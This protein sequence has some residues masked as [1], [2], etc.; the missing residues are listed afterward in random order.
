MKRVKSARIKQ[1]QKRNMIILS[2]IIICLIAIFIFNRWTRSEILKTTSVK[3]VENGIGT[4]VIS[5]LDVHIEEGGEENRYYVILPDKVNGYIVNKLFVNEDAE[6]QGEETDQEN[7]VSDN[8]IADDTNTI[9]EDS[10]TVSNVV[11]KDTNTLSDNI[12][13]TVNDNSANSNT[14]NENTNTIVE[15]DNT[16]AQ[17]IDSQDDSLFDKAINQSSENDDETVDEN[18]NT[19]TTTENTIVENSNTVV[20]NKDE[21]VINTN[22]TVNNDYTNTAS[23]TAIVNKVVENTV[24]NTIKNTLV[25]STNTI[26]DST[27]TI[28]D[29]TIEES[30]ELKEVFPGNIVYL[31]EDE[32][33]ADELTYIVEFNTKEINGVRLYEQ[34]LVAETAESNI[35]VKGFVPKDYLLNVV[36][37]DP[38][39]IQ[40]L[41]EDMEEFKNTTVLAAYDITIMKEELEY[42][43]VEFNQF[44]NVAITSKEKLE[45]NEII[46]K[47]IE[48]I[49]INETEEEIIFERLMVSNKTTDTVECDTNE[50]SRYAVVE[51]NLF[52]ADKITI[53]NFDNDY[54]YY[55]GL[56]YTEN[57]VG[58]E[59][60]VK[61]SKDNLAKVTVNYYGYKKDESAGAIQTN[62]FEWGWIDNTTQN[63]RRIIRPN[64]IVTFDDNQYVDFS[65]P[66]KLAFM[67]PYGYES[68]FNLEATQQH[69]ANANYRVSRDGN[70]IVIEADNWNSWIALSFTRYYLNFAMVFNQT[71]DVTVNNTRNT[72]SSL[73]MYVNGTAAIPRGYI[74]TAADERQSLMTY[75]HAAPINSDGSVSIEL[76][77]NPFVDRP[78]GR[79]FDGWRA[80]NTTDNTITMNGTNCIQTLTTRQSLTANANGVKE[81]TVDLYAN[82]ATANVIIYDQ[83]TDGD[84]GTFESPVNTWAEINSR[85]TGNRKYATAA[86]SRELNIIVIT[87]GTLYDIN[88]RNAVPYT[89]TSIYGG[90]DYRNEG[91]FRITVNSTSLNKDVQLAF[92]SI[93]GSSNYRNGGTGGTG[94]INRRIIGNTYNLRLGRGMMPTD[95]SNDAATWAQIQGG[96]TARNTYKLV[97]ESGKY[98]NLQVGRRDDIKHNVNAIFVAGNDID[99]AKGTTSERNTFHVYGKIASHSGGNKYNA[100]DKSKPLFDMRIK[101]GTIGVDGYNALAG[102]SNDAAYCGIYLGGHG[103]AQN[104]KDTRVL[105]IEGGRIANVIG[106][107]GTPSNN[108]P[109]T[110]IYVKGGTMMNIVGGA[111][112]SETYGDRCIQVTD[113]NVEYSINGGSNGVYSGTNEGILSGSSLLYV[114]GNAIIGSAVPDDGNPDNYELYGSKAGCVMG[115]GNGNGSQ[116]QAGRVN[117]SRII[118]DGNALIKNSV[119]GGGNYGPIYGRMPSYMQGTTVNNTGL[120]PNK[121][122]MIGSG[123]ESGTYFNRNGNNLS[124]A[125]FTNSAFPNNSQIWVFEDAG[126]GSFYIKNTL[127]NRYLSATYQTSTQSV[128]L[129]GESRWNNYTVVTAFN[130][131]NISLAGEANKT[132]FLITG[133]LTSGYTIKPAETYTI[134]SYLR[135][136]WYGNV[137]GNPV[138]KSPDYYLSTTSTTQMVASSTTLFIRIDE[139]IVE[140][141]ET[142][143]DPLDGIIAPIMIDILGGTINRN[144]YGGPNQKYANGNVK[145]TMDAGT[146]YGAIYG[147]SNQSGAISGN[148]DIRVRGGTLGTLDTVDSDRIFG[149]GKGRSTS[150][151]GNAS[152]YINDRKN[153]L[154]IYGNTFG[155]SEA[156]GVAGD[157]IVTM[158]DRYVSANSITYSG[159]I[160]GGGKGVGATATNGANSTVIVD[161]GTYQGL[162]IFG[163]CDISGTIEGNILVKVGE[164]NT[165]KVGSVYGAGRNSRVTNVTE[166]VYVH[167]YNNAMV[168]ENVFNGGMN[169]GIDGTNPRAVYINGATVLQNVYGGS[170]SSG[171]LQFT[172]VYCFNGA[173]VS[174]SVFG[175]GVGTGANVT[176]NTN[177]QI[178]SNK[179]FDNSGDEANS[180]TKIY[181][182]VYGGGENAAV[183][184]NTV[185]NVTNA[186]I[187]NNVFGGG[188]KANVT[189]DTDVDIISSQIN[190]KVFG[191]GD[192]AAVSGETTVDI[193]GSNVLE[194]VYGGGNQGALGA[195]VTDKYTATIKVSNSSDIATVYGGGAAAALNGQIMID[196]DNSTID[197][198]YGAGEGQ[199]SNV[200]QT[201]DV[202]VSDS[203][204]NKIYGGGFAG[205]IAGDIMIGV[206][207]CTITD[208]VYGAGQGEQAVSS[209]DTEVSIVDSI[210]ATN[211]FGGGDAG[212]LGG[213][214]NV[215]VTNTKVG[216]NAYGGGNKADV[217]ESTSI[218]FYEESTAKVV[219]GGGNNGNVG[220]TTSVEVLERSKIADTVY[221]GGNNGTVGGFT[222]VRVDDSDVENV[223]FGGGKGATAT[224]QGTSIAF[225][226][227]STTE[228]I[229]GGGDQGRVEGSTA[230]QTTVIVDASTVGKNV[231]AGG[232]G[233]SDSTTKG[234]VTGNTNLIIRNNATIGDGNQALENGEA[235]FDIYGD[236][237]YNGNAFG[238]GR[239][240]TA[241]VTGDTNVILN[242]S[243]VKYNIYGGGDN[244]DIVGNTTVRLTNGT[245]E[246]SAFAAGNGIPDEVHTN[247]IARVHENSHIILEG[248]TTVG[249]HVFGSGNAAKTGQES[250]TTSKAIVDI[251]GG[252]IGKS[253]YGG[254]NSSL[255]NGDTVTNIGVKAIDRY[256]GTAQGYQQDD[257][258]ING[259][260]FGGGE[261]MKVG[262]EGFDFFS[263]SVTGTTY[264]NVDGDTYNTATGP[265]LDFKSSIF[266]SGNASSANKSGTITIR[267]YGTLNDPKSAISLQRAGNV[268]IDK[269]ALWLSGTTDS[270]SKYADTYF[271]LNIIDKFMIKNNSTLYLRNGANKVSEFWSMTGEDGSETKAVV[272]IPTIITGVDGET[273]NAV[274]TKAKKGSTDYLVLD[275]V[276]YNKNADGT[277]GEKV[278]DVDLVETD[279][280]NI[281]YNVDNRIYMYS[282]INLDIAY[283]EGPSDSDYGPVYGMTFFGMYKNA[284]GTEL[285]KGMYDEDYSQNSRV[286]W[287][288]RDYNRCYVQGQHKANHVIE[289][290]G[291]YTSFEQLQVELDAGESLSQ[292]KY[293]DTTNG[294]QRSI[295]Y[296]NY[297]D[298]TPEESAYYMWYCGPDSE[299]FYYTFNLVASKFSTLGTK[300][301]TLD[302]IS[303]PNATIKLTTVES[304]LIDTANLVDKNTIPNINP[305]PDAANNVLGL[306]MKTGNSGWAMNGETNYYSENSVASRDGDSVYIIEN[307]GKSPALDFYLYHSNNITVTQELGYY[308]VNAEMSW[309]K[310][311]TRGTARII[312]D[313]ALSTAVYEGNYYN[314]AITPGRQFE[315][316]TTTP[317]DITTDSSFSAFFELS[318]YEFYEIEEVQKMYNEDAYRVLQTDYQLPVN[319]TITM[320]DRHD[321]ANPTY[322]YYT[323]TQEDVTDQKMEYLLSDF[324]EMGNTTKKYDEIGMMDKYYDENTKYQY[325]CFIFTVD[326][327][328]AE[329]ADKT[330]F[331]IAKDQLFTMA[332]RGYEYDDNGNKMG[333]KPIFAVMDEQL[334]N[335]NYGLYNTE[336]V[337]KITDADL[338]KDTIYPGSNTTLE[339]EID[340]NDSDDD[341]AETTI[342][343]HDTRFFDKKMGV[344]ISLT[345]LN[346][347]TGVYEVVPGSSLMGTYFTIT[348]KDTNGDE[349]KYN[350]YPR[351]DGT[352]RIKLAEKVS[353]L[354]SEIDINTEN[355]TLN[356]DFKI[357][358]E[359]FGSADGI[360]FGVEAS[361]SREVD[362]KVVD[363]IYG[364]NTTIPPEQ[365][366]IDK[367]TGHT[368]EPDTGYIS[369][370]ENAVDVTLEYQSGLNRPYIT[371]KLLRRNYQTVNSTMYEIVDLQDYVNETLTPVN[372]ENEYKALDTS[373]IN[374]AV[375]NPLN[376]EEFIFNYTT[377]EDLVSGTYKLL[378]TLY[379]L[380]DV[381]IEDKDDNGNVTGTHDETL[382]QYI[383]DTHSYLVIK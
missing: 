19:N 190:K 307:S 151:N 366:I 79:G 254:A 323:V 147:G 312:I 272:T 356:G 331:E 148:V 288:D 281:S 192:E 257:I 73:G 160:F 252:I 183:G 116:Q 128:K 358:I 62:R 58:R 133:S 46:K 194:A 132:K 103:S 351:A 121:K 23:N 187:G 96:G 233:A 213:T 330:T 230:S 234:S 354:F 93:S 15:K 197:T 282:G 260:I 299:V 35:V 177:V 327:E 48:M 285:Y 350:Y 40:K 11:T 301:L 55:M 266:A 83:D 60:D 63:Q 196:V 271:T 208:A 325:E 200:T 84:A 153:N 275:G 189:G 357:V 129:D 105:T 54:N 131:V 304:S 113:G 135:N 382:Y 61:Y 174:G 222:S 294:D 102:N 277:A 138:T 43:P 164:E 231:F 374:A 184:G 37:E 89:I 214:A 367:T 383:G 17:D 203:T 38:T 353:N 283:E 349:H 223:V 290:D 369:E 360:Y 136:E 347:D 107:L 126:D 176:G 209:G 202:D 220:T 6:V 1:K 224:V 169:A 88:T 280:N 26:N 146:V 371:V 87:D 152:I 210:V 13:T 34:E 377:K 168:Y 247:H 85:L 218:I 123:Q 31:T 375:E 319:T 361:D 317:T 110:F 274:G 205:D 333:Y 379:D 219:Y 10:N 261:S 65:K 101:S 78:R 244:G 236:P 81:V 368:L 305:D 297:I 245:V 273:Y 339:L 67:I 256:Y 355:S 229:Y 141:P 114:G 198:I 140:Q 264:I 346:N 77:D 313:I 125:T 112:R 296:L 364:L 258:L 278:T 124:T 95:T 263:I 310:N 248:T 28:E 300:S 16:D 380:E 363:N 279:V 262:V 30:I 80:I 97:I 170:D 109:F 155:G 293:E 108:P 2:T 359:S 306:A 75:T 241:T 295:S 4:E 91:S 302:G 66:F 243:T 130:G 106:G 99:R 158:E 226:N 286:N 165:T 181:T 292:T 180:T 52:T 314:A 199:A 29:T 253:V 246:S 195:N 154:T 179:I 204:V 186:Q 53:N 322:Y 104:D 3:F 69:A 76:I 232:N 267:N 12:N 344:R 268:I 191:G 341:S 284:E 50:F 316:F 32:V 118:I 376:I 175:A 92:L 71:A 178:H 166:S 145:I 182:N 127:N 225:Q 328:S 167:C 56:N 238:G 211:V 9:I 352:T 41:M 207:R 193:N 98:C 335:M 311:L 157:S 215:F 320:I 163:G 161:G 111:G 342:A 228:Y 242:S 326:F 47:D 216:E 318:E 372:G 8:T 143:G 36:N 378:Y 217:D 221:G 57:M 144:V 370:T 115:A 329:F 239:G 72:P 250:S 22:T 332:L 362:L 276:I 59:D 14:V 345:Q 188:Q 336:S 20:D 94:N 122:Y 149:G 315:L 212:E 70:A 25:Q 287:V 249:K 334:K 237:I 27:N 82:W 44:V 324:L 51:N 172:N 291:F 340:Y 119:Y 240:L 185:V 289:E 308:R 303:Y 39:E 5:E 255:V 321:N 64:A 171:A 373:E 270:T 259:T 21:N 137:Y 162:T 33:I 365:T 201:T 206:K 68:R 381:E 120:D 117:S 251:A 7:T 49:H 159:I 150:I 227:G 24:V 269:S 139:P 74:S 309:K 134:Y 235:A 265:T 45:S 142:D 343:V 156:G 338:T 90:V 100:A 337:I 18:T 86:S 173:S 42:Q 298:P 348:Q